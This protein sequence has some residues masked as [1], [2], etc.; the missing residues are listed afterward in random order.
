MP[1]NWIIKVDN[2]FHANP[3]C[4][5]A[6]AHVDTFPTDLPLEPNIREPNRKS[7]TYRQIFDSLTTEPQKFFERHSGIVLCA[8]KVKPS[9]DKK[10]LELEVLEAAE[11][12]NDGIINGGHTVLAFD[13]AKNYKYDLSV[14]RV[15]ITIHVGL[16]E[17]EAKDI[18]LASNTTSPVDSRSKVNARG[19]YDFIK[20]YLAQLELKESRKFRVAYYQNQS[21]VPKNTHCNVTHFFKLL[22]CLD[23]NRYNPEGNTRSKHPAVSNSPSQLS[24]AERERLTK[25]LPLLTKAMWIE[26]RLYE[27]IQEYISKPKRKGINDLA[28]I[29]MRKN[30]LLADSRYSFGFGAPGDL[31]LPIVASYRVFLDKDYNWIVPFEDFSED[32]L[33][34]LWDSYF[35]KYLISEKIA[36][37]TVGAKICRNQEIW[38]SLYIFAQSYLNQLLVKMV[39]SAKR[40]ELTLSQG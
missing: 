16:E 19:D 4:I 30:T 38:D 32:F 39:N 33:Q 24:D 34:Q 40:E 7:S 23:R 27:I 29:D 37:N 1:K 5:I 31:A 17:T 35:R 10:Q 2:Y 21:G 15:K 26:Q 8:N 13:S 20:S 22:N 14:A 12:G 11:G 28:S 18:A 36:G 3:D 25:L 9:K 6:T